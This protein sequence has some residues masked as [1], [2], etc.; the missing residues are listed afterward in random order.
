MMP[1]M[2]W[3]AALLFIAITAAASL[4]QEQDHSMHNM[5]HMDHSMPDQAVSTAPAHTH[6]SGMLDGPMSKEASGTAWQPQ[7]TPMHGLHFSAGDWSF[8]LHGK[9]D[10][11]FTHGSGDRGND[12]VFSDNMLMIMATRPLGAGTLGVRAML[13]AEPATIGKGGYPELFQTGETANGSTPLVDR[14][15]PHDLFMELAATYSV[16]VN[17]DRDSIFFYAGLPGEPELGPATFMHRA[18]GMDNPEAPI[19]HHWL[20][21][22]HV[23]FGVL[24]AGYIWNEMVKIDGSIFTG[25]EPDEH[26][27]DIEEPKMDSQSIRLTVNPTED[28]SAQISFGHINSPEQLEP[29]V[30]QNRTTVSITYNRR[31]GDRR[32]N[33][34][35]TTL[36]WGRNNN[37]PGDTLD[38]FLLESAVNFNRT[39][40]IFGR[41]EYV[42]KDELFEAPSPLT[43]GV[44]WITKLS[45]GYVYDFP[46]SHH[47]QWGIGAEG[48]V[49]FI[50]EEIQG[51][52]GDT[53]T[54]VLFFARVRL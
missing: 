50:P 27:Y 45:L 29:D 51:A 52:Y 33:N 16:P 26:R 23:S 21:S 37:D 20:D 13:S 39:H 17:A 43:G 14:Q 2:T 30:D 46:A 32:E 22:T 19:T 25:R 10:L 8:M 54:S 3:K 42:Q 35:Q 47:V 53:P 4:A 40:T 24:T 49:H 1:A 41:A 31:F 48:N 6:G 5:E 15:H 38:G 18:S 12:K 34:W 9:A 7:S 44:F 36:A 28:W 11:V